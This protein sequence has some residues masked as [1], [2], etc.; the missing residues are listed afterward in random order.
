MDQ[1]T[2][3]LYI[4]R[5]VSG[6][7]R[8]SID[9]KTYLIK[10]PDRYI[11]YIAQ[12][13]YIEALRDAEL[14][15]LYNEEELNN[16][17]YENNIWSDEKEKNLKTLIE[18]IDELKVK[19]YQAAFKSEERKALR[20]LLTVAKL[21]YGEL[22]NL[23]TS[24]NYLSCH[25]TASMMK[26]R[27]ILG[28]TL[29]YEDGEKVWRND[30]FWK[31]TDPLLEDIINQYIENKINDNEF[32]EIARTDPWRSTWSC[33]KSEKEVFGVSTVDLTE[34]QKS[35]VIWSS[36][37]DTIYEHPNCPQQEIIDDDD[38]IDGW[39]IIQRRERN[40]NQTKLQVD[41][42]ISNDK[43]K[44]SKEVFVIGQSKQDRERIESLND[45]YAKN[46]KRQRLNLINKRGNVDEAE[47]PDTKLDLQMQANKS[48]G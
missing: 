47:M 25:S 44:N 20:K 23:K 31:N 37:Y 16:F 48:R 10:S 15:G 4:A 39:L 14:E 43:I 33:K 45:D 30:D 12:E 11:R 27:Y 40:K 8:C 7:F 42:L 34:E 5:I 18:D 9:G 19:L 46:V 3:E 13:I 35:I 29:T 38:L 21:K 26:V 28:K 6:L 22:N 32:R 1:A 17:L 36:I 2:K 24:Y 41:D